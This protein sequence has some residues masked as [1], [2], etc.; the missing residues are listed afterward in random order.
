[1]SRQRLRQSFIEWKSELSHSSIIQKLIYL[2]KEEL[3]N[4]KYKKINV[5]VSPYIKEYIHKNFQR[6]IENIEDIRKVSIEILDD[7]SL[8]NNEIKIENSDEE[9]VSKIKKKKGHDE[10]K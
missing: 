7:L 9:K 3:N 1:M 4:K 8:D 6:D 2:I 10:K 5:R